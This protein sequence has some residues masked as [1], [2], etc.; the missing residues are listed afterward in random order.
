MEIN[1]CIEV[2]LEIYGECSHWFNT[3]WMLYAG[4]CRVLFMFQT[5]KQNGVSN[6]FQKKR[7]K[8]SLFYIGT[9]INDL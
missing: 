4:E 8:R 7:N 2:E 5:I 9:D 3:M 6:I 1:Y